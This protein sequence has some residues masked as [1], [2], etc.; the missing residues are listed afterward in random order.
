M[1]LQWSAHPI[2][3]IPSAEEGRKMAEAGVL[4]EYWQQREELIRLEKENAFAYGADH[5]NTQDIPHREPWHPKGVFAHWKE[6]DAAL[7]DPNV[8]IIYIFGG[9]RGGKSRY[10]A[11]RVVRMMVNKP[12]Y[13][14][15]CCHSS[16]DSSIQVQQPYIF[17]Y[18]PHAWKEQKRTVRSVVNV[19]FTQK[20]GFSNRTFVGINHSQCWFRNYTQDLGTLEGTELDLIWMDE[21]VPLSWVETLKYR[22][23]TRKGKMIVTFTP[24]DGYTPT[25][26]DAME[27]AIIEETQPAKL[28]DPTWPSNISGVPRGHMPTV[29]RTRSGRGKIFWFFTEWNPF[30]PFKQMERTLRGRNREEVEIRAYGYVTNPV[31]GKFPAFTDNNIVKPEEIPSEGTNYMCVDPTGGD[32]N[33]FMLWLR[34]DDLGR[35]FVYRE[36]PDY[37]NYGEWALPSTKLDGKAGPAQTADCGRNIHEYRKLIRELERLD[38]PVQERYIDPRAGR[39]AVI[40]QREHNQSLI[41]ILA[42][43]ERGAGGEVTKDGL[44]FVPAAML[45]VDESCSMVNH[46]FRYNTN[47]ELSILNEPKLYVSDA[48]KN[49]IYSLK[50]WTNADGQKG[51]SKDPVDVLRYMISMDPMH[52]QPN[53]DYTTEAGSY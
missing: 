24:I 34:V 8:D 15:W 46:L 53:A 1:D 44:V 40:G 5:H 50:T 26:K 39:A 35:M 41:D 2:L 38:G 25:V 42:A 30:N 4:G 18:L 21:L 52:V 6:V 13:K 19:A 9:N 37:K 16:N 47:E 33:W 48:C 20:N 36:W 7:D 32:R 43:P 45:E 31:V 23:V 27:G 49:L 29:G 28:I 10:V 51:A 17:E 14:V 3:H 12:D 22:L 11:S